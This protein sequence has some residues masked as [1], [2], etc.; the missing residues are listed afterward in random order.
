MLITDLIKYF[1]GVKKNGQG[2]KALCPAHDDH[3]PSLSISQEEEKILINCHAGCNTESIMQQIGLELTDLFN[4]SE[5]PTLEKK[6]QTRQIEPIEPR[7]I[8]ELHQGCTKDAQQYLEKQ[9]A[10][11]SDVV[12]RYKI[13]IQNKGERRVIIP[14]ANESGAYTDARRWL[15][16]EIRTKNQAK[17]LHWGKGYGAPRLFP[18]DQLQ[19]NEL[20]LCEGELDAL[21]L[22]S[23]GIPAI[24]ATC[25]VTTW[26]DALSEKFNKKTVIILTDN[27]DA[28]R[29]GAQLRANSLT[30]AGAQVKIATW[31]EDRPEGWAGTDE[32]KTSLENIKTLIAASESFSIED[33]WPDPQPLKNETPE[34]ANFE[35]ELLPSGLKD[36]VKDTAELMQCP[37]DF[38]AVPAM[39]G[40]G[41]VVGRQIAIRPKE[42]DDW[43]VVPNLFGAIV[44]S[45][46]LMKSA[47]ADTMLEPLKQ[48][49]L[50]FYEDY[51]EAQTRHKIECLI[52]EEQIKLTRQK[53]NQDLKMGIDPLHSAMEELIE[54]EEPA[55]K[56]IMLHDTTIEKLGEILNQNPRG[57]LIFRDELTGWL[58]SL[59][60]DGREGD[61]AFYLEA[62][63]GTGRFTYDRIGRGTTEIEAACVSIFGCIQPGPLTHYMQRASLGGADN[64]GL[65]Q[66]FQLVVWP[67]TPKEWKLHDRKP[68]KEARE[69]AS[70]I[71]Q[72]LNNIDTEAL[73]AQW[74]G[75]L[76]Y[77]RFSPEAQEI[78]NAWRGELE[79][80]I[81]SGNE[82]EIIEAHLA[83]FRSLIPSLALLAHLT[84]GSPGPVSEEAID[85]ACGWA[86]YLETHARKIYAPALNTA[87]F[88]THSLAK[89]ILNKELSNGFTSRDI[90]R[91]QW[92]GLSSK[93]EV[94]EAIETLEENDWIKSNIEKKGG[95]PKAFYTINPKLLIKGVKNDQLA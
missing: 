88:A 18:I 23:A 3:N 17:I 21:A 75:G 12:A 8:E 86:Y 74:D 78:F 73:G 76:P 15:P 89:R 60:R 35:Y 47:A 80:K 54:P 9:R 34:V 24:T 33:N 45:P 2:F 26:P 28:G 92:S 82:P 72:R 77:L 66:R 46:G 67:N 56:R 31:P 30:A 53:I 38:L 58:R 39:I 68:N 13:G 49:D 84:D 1:E 4:N 87:L 40:L 19:A 20:I 27:D 70:Q 64:D 59:E 44:G 51:K 5:M 37:P 61:R 25:G 14:I 48:L 57:I 10:I 7:L 52:A 22:I 41:A 16:P 62:W 32:L 85:K 69:K 81:R 83:K 50:E 42:R 79:E 36:W 91:R 55:R 71:Y 94:Q 63:N 95:R 43:T 11:T 6:P 29:Q 90:Y 93:E 65:V